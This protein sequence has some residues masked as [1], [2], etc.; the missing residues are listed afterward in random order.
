[1]DDLELAIDLCINTT[2]LSQLYALNGELINKEV[3]KVFT[4]KKQSL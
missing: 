2:E 3:T 1:V 4:N